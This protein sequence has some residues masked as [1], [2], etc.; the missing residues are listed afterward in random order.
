MFSQVFGGREGNILSSVCS[1]MYVCECSTCA[2]LC[3]CAYTA[4]FCSVFC[5]LL[6]Y[7]FY[8][9]EKDGGA[10]LSYLEVLLVSSKAMSRMLSPCM[11]GERPPTVSVPFCFYV[12]FYV[13]VHF[14]YSSDH[15]CFPFWMDGDDMFTDSSRF[16]LPTYLFLAH[17]LYG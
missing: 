3:T 2:L 10:D 4:I 14:L 12:V 15:T 7:L 17:G 13:F 1:L 11:F 5:L 16:I 8:L 9:S 6:R